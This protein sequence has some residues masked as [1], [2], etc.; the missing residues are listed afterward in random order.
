MLKKPIH[1][2]IKRASNKFKKPRSGGQQVSTRN[3]IIEKTPVL[4]E[5]IIVSKITKEEEDKFFVEKILQQKKT[6]KLVEDPYIEY[7]AFSLSEE[8][9]LSIE[10]IEE[11]EKKNMPV[12]YYVIVDFEATCDKDNKMS[13]DDRE[14][15][16][17]AAILMNKNTRFIEAEFTMFVKPVINPNLTEYCINLTTIL[18]SDVDEAFSFS[19]VFVQFKKWMDRYPGKK[20]FC[21]WGSYDKEQLH[22]DCERHGV[23]YPFNKEHVDISK[24]FS[25]IKGYKR[26]Y[27]LFSALKKLKLSFQGT[28]HRGIDDAKNIAILYQRLLETEVD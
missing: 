9:H 24:L 6:Q 11:I 1:N 15:I 5:N 27:S 20:I 23:N 21:S 14:I 13:N 2:A 4:Q 28:K 12:E 18:Q 7:E 10:E 16:E 22:V 3:L 8:G 25:S 17:F 26:S 19:T